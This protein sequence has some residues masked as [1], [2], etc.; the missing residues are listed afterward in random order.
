LKN[1][2]PSCSPYSSYTSSS[3]VS[4]RLEQMVRPEVER[5][6]NLQ[7]LSAIGNGP[8]FGGQ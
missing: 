3:L 7:T 6:Q 8:F 5:S 4:K 2:S 1:K